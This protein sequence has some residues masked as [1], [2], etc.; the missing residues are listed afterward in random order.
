MKELFQKLKIYGE[1]KLTTE[2]LLSLVFTEK[3]T[4]EENLKIAKNLIENGKDFTGDLRFLIHI[5]INELME[6]GLEIE[7][8]TRL[9]AISGIVKRLCYP[10]N[11]EKLEMNSSTD[12]ANLFI[13][14]LR[15]EKLEKVKIVILN[16][17]NIVLKIATLSK[18]T[19]NSATISIK[20]ILSEPVRMKATKI[21]LV[22]N[23]PSRRFK[24]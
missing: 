5:S 3:K 19:T 20:D 6:Q 22:H 12:V 14:E 7:D 4:K 2:E 24:A 23:H 8:A 21:I 1:D 15:F 10:T 18:G 11:L 16:N 13:P 17:K 9:K